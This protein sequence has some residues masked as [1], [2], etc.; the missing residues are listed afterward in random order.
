MYDY[1][2]FDLGN[3]LIR[4]AYERVLERICVDAECSRD[5]LVQ[6][7]EEGGGY[8]DLE[9]G[10]VSFSEFHEFLQDRVSYSGSLFQL[11]KVWSD[12]FDGPIDGIEEVLDRARERYKVA[13]LSNS[14]EVHEE[15]IPVS[16]AALFRRD[17]PFIFSHRFHSAKPDSEIF[18][19]A[20]EFLKTEPSRVLYVDDLLENVN[21][22]K[23]VGM[24]AFQFTT[25]NELL[26]ELEGEGLL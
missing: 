13:F 1:F 26:R 24:H 22:A 9:R 3:V 4:L 10:A 16:F 12:F 7:M 2:I 15:V 25:A 23:N 17:E 8:R 5:E 6:L 20:C 18:F 14:N 21:A 11:R 19:K